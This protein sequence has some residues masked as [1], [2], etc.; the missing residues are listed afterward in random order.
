VID[1]LWQD[2]AIAIGSAV[3]LATK[4]YALTDSRTVWTRRSSLTNAAFYPPSIAAFASLELWLTMTT[5]L[6]SF[7]LWVGIAI[8]RAPDDEDWFGRRQR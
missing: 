1:I 4:A 3:G 2:V 8:W 6:A 5:T 7:A